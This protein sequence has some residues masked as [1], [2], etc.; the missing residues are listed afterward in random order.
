M[1]AECRS[2]VSIDGARHQLDVDGVE[3]WSR[4][5]GWRRVNENRYATWWTASPIAWSADHVAYDL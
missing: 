3:L 2:Y 5:V 4:P 1:D